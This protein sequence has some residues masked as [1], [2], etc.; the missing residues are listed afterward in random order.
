[1]N[2]DSNKNPISLLAPFSGQL[3]P[4]E[5]VGDGVFSAK[6]L[7][8][9]IAIEPT[10]SAVCAPADGQVINVFPTG[11]AY[12]INTREGLSLL[13]HVGL[14]SVQLRGEGFRVL[15][16]AGDTVKAGQRIAEVDLERMRSLGLRTVSMC[17]VCEGGEGLSMAAATGAVEAG[18][19]IVL[20]LG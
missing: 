17:V 3:I 15:V 13:I 8:D 6:L 19:D 11:H 2:I 5:E 14:D 18:R 20:T 1:M 7:G 16:E 10:G 4:L 9:G 12:V